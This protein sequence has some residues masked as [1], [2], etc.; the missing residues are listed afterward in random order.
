MLATMVKKAG[1]ENEE[2][3]DVVDQAKA[4]AMI[5]QQITKWQRTYS[6]SKLRELRE[7]VHFE[8]K[9]ILSKDSTSLIPAILCEVCNK[10]TTMGFKSR[11]VLL[12]NWTRHIVK[13][14]GKQKTPTSRKAKF[15]II[16]HVIM[17]HLVNLPLLLKYL[18]YYMVNYQI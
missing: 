15:K 18:K 4:L 12:S 14:V 9:V 2:S 6:L 10:I 1:Y 8:I 5:R 3:D 16:F 13:C 7:N 11:N 17:H